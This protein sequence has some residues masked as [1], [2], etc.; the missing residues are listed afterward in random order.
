[1]R[2]ITERI[3]LDE[4][5]IAKEAAEK[6]AQSK[7]E[8][9]ANISHEIRTPMNA[10]IGFSNLALQ[11]SLTPKLRRYLN[12]VSGSAQNLL[13]LINDILDFSKIEAE[14]LEIENVDFKLGEVVRDVSE[15]VSLK[16][17]EKDIRFTV[18]I[19]PDVPNE[20]VG[21][22]LRLSQ[23]LLN[24]ANNAVKFTLSGSVIMRVDAA[25]ITADRC[26]LTFSVEDTGIGMTEAQLSKLFQPFSQADSSITRRFGGTGLGL[27]ICKRLVEIMGGR[28]QVQSQPGRGSIFSFTV[29]FDRR[30]PV[31][32]AP[33]DA[34]AVSGS[35]PDEKAYEYDRIEDAEVL[36]VEDNIINQ[37]LT[38]ELLEGMGL[39]VD[40]ANTG[41]E[42][43]ERIHAAAY[44]L[45]L[46][47]VQ[48]PG[49]SGLE[50]T[51]RIR[52]IE[53]LKDIP[54]VAMTAHDTANTKKECLAAGMNDFIAKP[55]DV[56]LLMSVLVKWLAPRP[57]RNEIHAYPP[58]RSTEEADPGFHVPESLPGIQFEQGLER[59][60]GNK[61]LYLNLLTSFVDRYVPAASEIAEAIGENNYRIVA[62]Q[63]HTIKGAAANLSLTDVACRAKQLEHAVRSG[64]P[65]DI[66]SAARELEDALAVALRS[67]T[68]LADANRNQGRDRAESA[69]PDA[70]I[71]T[72]LIRDL[73]A[74]LKKN[75]L[76][77]VRQFDALKRHMPNRSFDTELNRLESMLTNLDFAGALHLLDD[78]AENINPSPRG[79]VEN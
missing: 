66:R 45:I 71:L 39:R 75:D 24:L 17:Q 26:R 5:R 4:L 68:E 41:P 29:G 47:D 61:R 55:L 40:I 16:A 67:V 79:G 44:D 64:T 28:I 53:R 22:P 57:G 15:I 14:H 54:I 46:M 59:L 2:E 49:M 6:T 21:D 78:L 51:A 18:S 27:A 37:Q 73:S 3:R 48:L 9:L 11:N 33:P 8:F 65:E 74:S 50:A 69:Q 34:E 36:L 30:G 63:A 42:A 20:L 52:K 72:S 77:A 19:G 62:D 25:D 43:L 10:I 58:D 76:R 31:F 23:V 60:Q 12:I 70:A 7:N 35:P 38:T 56:E 1:M 13:H 32:G